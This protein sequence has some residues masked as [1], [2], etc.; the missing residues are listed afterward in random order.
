MGYLGVLVFVILSALSSGGGMGQNVTMTSLAKAGTQ[1]FVAI[2]YGQVILICLISPMFMAGAIAAEQSGKTFDIM[3]TTPLTNLQVVLGTLFGRLFFIW[4]LLASGLPLFS[5][6]LIFG[7]VPISAVFVAFATAALS[8][9]VMGAVAVALAVLRIGG[10]KAVVTF[11]IAMA[12]YLVGAYMVDQ[13]LLRNFVSIPNTTT[14]LTPLHPILVLESWLNRAN[15]HPPQPEQVAHLPKIIGFYL[16]RPFATF[17]ILSSLISLGL[18]LWCAIRVRSVGQGESLL[19]LQVRRWLRLRGSGGERRRPPRLVWHNP[20]A[21]REANTRGKLAAGILGRWAF[22]VLGLGLAILW[23]WLYHA[24]KMPALPGTLPHEVFHQGL[25]VLLIVETSVIALVGLYMSASCVSREREDQTLDLILTTPISPKYYIW[26]KLR[27]LV[28]F[29]AF[30]LAV[31]ILTVAIV[32]A[33]AMIGRA[34][35]LASTSV[36]YTIGS[37]ARVESLMLPEAPL[38]LA[39]ILIP[40][41]AFCVVI[42]MNWSLRSKGVLGAVVPT[43]GVVMIVTLI[44]SFC[45]IAAAGGIPVIGPIINSFSPFTSMMTIINPWENVSGFID[46]PGPGRISMLV[47]ALAATGG[48]GAISYAVLL[49]TISGFDHTVRQLSGEG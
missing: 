21:W 9:L 43:L 49:A 12:A 36:S 29:L 47:G 2:A 7:G 8:A 10:R 26:G 11:V 28:S 31:P 33:Y 27:G 1:V 23:L 25:L 38:F 30:M 42:G 15:Y 18:L 6:L 3:L 20:I 19:P 48:Y 35:Q 14:W 41:V 22:V 45:G 37:T 34:N 16:A 32:A 44:I 4:A 40:F 24:G 13:F 5:I 46:N 39:L 17:T